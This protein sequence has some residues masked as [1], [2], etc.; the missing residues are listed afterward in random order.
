[1]PRPFFPESVALAW[2]F[3]AVLVGI[4]LI[5]TYT[6]LRY[7]QIPKWLTLPALALGVLVNV[8]L[9][10]MTDGPRGSEHPFLFG[11]AGG[12]LGALSGLLLALSGCAVGFG[13][14]LVMFVLGTCRGG[15]VKLFAAVGAW[16]GP[17]L[18][19][20]LLAGTIVAVV[21]MALARLGWNAATHGL[22]ATAKD[23]TL[24][25]AR[26]QRRKS[27]E[28]KETRRRLMAYSPAMALSAALMLLWIFG[29]ELHVRTPKERHS[30]VNLANRLR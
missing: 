11:G 3:Y 2:T 25:G 19:L 7:L 10:A 24:K 14:F 1:M 15:D 18:I 28:P 12:F 20:V 6:D 27:V 5:A 17:V 21:F 26:T 8:V 13:L 16:V 9:G 22:R 29:V 30:A 23:Y 4:T